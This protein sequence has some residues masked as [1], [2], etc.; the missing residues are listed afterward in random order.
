[1][2]QIPEDIYNG[3]TSKSKTWLKVTLTNL[4]SRTFSSQNHFTIGVWNLLFFQKEKIKKMEFNGI[5]EA[6]TLNMIKRLQNHLRY[7]RYKSIGNL[8]DWVFNM[9][10]SMKMMRFNLHIAF[11]MSTAD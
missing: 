4:I 7:V 1:M 11:L 2:T 5:K 6:L 10:V 9:N 3:S 8:I